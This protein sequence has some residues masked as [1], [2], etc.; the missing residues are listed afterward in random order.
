[1]QQ[2][3]GPANKPRRDFVSMLLGV[4]GVLTVVPFLNIVL[5]YVTP[6]KL[7]VVTKE[8]IRVAAVEDIPPNSAKIVRFNKEP[9][10][11]VHTTSGQY[12][13]FFAR[14]THLGCVV[15]FETEG[16]P[17]FHCNCHGS[18]FDLT[19]R[20]LSGPAPTPLRPLKVSVQE[21]AVIVSSIEA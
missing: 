12:K 6:P 16:T 11:V 14:C 18:E 19:G 1:M 21:A 13:A 2:S 17:R 9:I 7:N 3:A 20:N 5:R 15:K 8:S 10:I 4:W